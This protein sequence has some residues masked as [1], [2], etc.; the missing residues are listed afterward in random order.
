MEYHVIGQEQPRHCFYT[1]GDLV[2]LAGEHKAKRFIFIGTEL[3]PQELSSW[4]GSYELPAIT[5]SSEPITGGTLCSNLTKGLKESHEAY[6]GG[7]Y[8]Y[9]DNEEFYVANYGNSSQYKVIGYEITEDTVTLLTRID[10][11]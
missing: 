5:Y 9:T 6:K 7:D 1:I 2:S 8:R 4:R 3:S 10:R 11:Y